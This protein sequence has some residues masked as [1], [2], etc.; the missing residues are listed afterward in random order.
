MA[1]SPSGSPTCATSGSRAVAAVLGVPQPGVPDFSEPSVVVADDL[2][3]A[4]TATLDR[5]LVVGIVTE[6]GGP[7]SHTAIL[8]AQLGIPAVV[9]LAGATGIPAGTPVAVDGDTGTVTDRPRTSPWSRRRSCAARS[10]RRRSPR[11]AA[12]APPAT[13]PTSRCWPTSAGSRTPTA[14]GLDVEGVGLFRTEFLFLSADQR[15]DRRRA[16]GDLHARCSRRSAAGA[17]SSARWTPA[18]TSRWP[19][20]TSGRRRTRRWVGGACDCRPAARAA[21][22]P[23][24]GARRGREGH[25]RRRVGDGADGGH[26]RGGRRSPGGS[27]RTACPRPG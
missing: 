20:P 23:A 2:A 22:R 18:P 14:A 5:T 27:A 26:R 15:A 4:D 10:G 1:T 24:R 11:A 19:S 16:G 3:P 12:P 6:A 13:A 7:T 21:R 17:S 25:R 9:Q 8:A